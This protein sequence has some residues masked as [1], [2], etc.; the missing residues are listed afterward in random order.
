M[1]MGKKEMWPALTGWVKIASVGRSR[2]YY[3]PPRNETS[4]WDQVIRK[5]LPF[6][7]GRETN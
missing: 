6:R 4:Y 5:A 3:E 2:P 1:I 7:E